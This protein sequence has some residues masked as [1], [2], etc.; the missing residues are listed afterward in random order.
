MAYT[1]E[2]IIAEK[3]ESIINKNITTTRAKDFYDLYMLMHKNNINNNNL[4]KAIKNTFHKRNT[5]YNIETFKEIIEL[6]KDNY[7]IKNVFNNY[8]KKM[9][10]VQNI[11]FEDTIKALNK[12]INILESETFV[13]N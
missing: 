10:Y 13:K 11:T 1:T 7:F 5:N 12:I 4:I 9:S 3:F 2:T 6:L 8:Q